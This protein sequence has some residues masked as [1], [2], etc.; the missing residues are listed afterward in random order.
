VA[1]WIDTV[2]RRYQFLHDM[3]E[4][5]QRWAQCNARHDREVIQ[6]LEVVCHDYA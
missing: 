6:A 3:T 1:E 2:R 4:D 5:E